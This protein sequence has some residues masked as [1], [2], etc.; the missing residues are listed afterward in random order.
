[1]WC[2]SFLRFRHG[3]N[4]VL[5]LLLFIHSSCGEEEHEIATIGAL[6]FTVVFFYVR[7]LL[8]LLLLLYIYMYYTS[9]KYCLFVDTQ[10]KY[11]QG[12]GG[13]DNTTVHFPPSSVILSW[14]WSR[15]RFQTMR[16][17]YNNVTINNFYAAIPAHEWNMNDNNRIAWPAGR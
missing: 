14:L 8:L 11:S 16:Y 10:I 13:K 15:A 17:E 5:L 9:T 1:M 7:M 6:G 4:Q 2:S 3:I 12:G